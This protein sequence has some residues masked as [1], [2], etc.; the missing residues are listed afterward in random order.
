[1]CVEVFLNVFFRVVVSEPEFAGA[2]DRICHDLE[3]TRV[4]LDRKLKDWPEIVFAKKLELGA[5]AGQR[6]VALKNT[7][8][9]LMHFTSSHQTFEH[10]GVVIHG[11][12][13]TTLYEDL[14]SESAVQA[15][16][17]AEEFLCEVFKLRG[18]S[19]AN[20]PHALHSWTGKPPI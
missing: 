13:D 4:G 11:L 14:S 19:E 9:R 16:G 18:I 2:A 17:T 7:R 5:G 20:L 15:L 8:H 1:V 3:D 10:A 12:A 6:F